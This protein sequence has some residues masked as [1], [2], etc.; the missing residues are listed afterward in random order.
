MT[1]N[2]PLDVHGLVFIDLCS[3]RDEKHDFLEKVHVGK[4]DCAP[5]DTK[6]YWCNPRKNE[7]MAWCMFKTRIEWVH[8]TRD[9]RNRN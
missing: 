5:S 4:K 6:T 7:R 8:V 9:V 3:A 2:A 1:R